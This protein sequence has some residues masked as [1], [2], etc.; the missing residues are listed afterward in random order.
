MNTIKIGKHVIEIDINKTRMAYNSIDFESDR[1]DC[2][3]CRNL[4]WK[5]ILHNSG[6]NTIILKECFKIKL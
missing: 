4:R 5:M 3:G 2:D 6:K 1:C